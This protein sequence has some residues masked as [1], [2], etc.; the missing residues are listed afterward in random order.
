MTAFAV[1]HI[2]KNRDLLISILPEVRKQPYSLTNKRK[3]A[4]SAAAGCDV[5]V[6]EV[7][8]AS[9]GPIYRLGYCYKAYKCDEAPS[10]KLWT[11]EFKYKNAAELGVPAQGF[12]FEHTVIITDLNFI[13][14]YKGAKFGMTEIPERH[15]NVLKQIIADPA[16][17]AHPFT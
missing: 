4:N 14:W 6:I 7:E 17:G 3:T 2:V 8:Y 10:S 5:Y 15:V 13:D 12:Y 16:N 1:K 11:G 9:S